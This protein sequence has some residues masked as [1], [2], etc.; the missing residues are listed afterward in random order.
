MGIHLTST[1]LSLGATGLQP[2]KS[3][4]KLIHSCRIEN[5]TLRSVVVRESTPITLYLLYKYS[6]QMPILHE[7]YIQSSDSLIGSINLNELN[8]I[9]LILYSVVPTACLDDD[10]LSRK[11]SPK[12]KEEH[13]SNIIK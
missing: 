12:R 2:W 4:V 10:Q 1:C 5:E 6:F 8:V 3:E 13:T 9:D 7:L 11:S